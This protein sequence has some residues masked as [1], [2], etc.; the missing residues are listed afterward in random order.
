MKAEITLQEAYEFAVQK[1]EFLSQHDFGSTY[2]A[3]R[4]VKDDIPVLEQFR[5]GCAYCA[6]FNY[7]INMP[8]AC[9]GCPLYEQGYSCLDTDFGPY[10]NWVEDPSA[11]NAQIM[12]ETIILCK[13]S[14]STD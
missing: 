7:A 12:L 5:A 11:E 10:P 13:P 6:L 8:N 1:W 4:A 2:N 14:E 9:V 3:E